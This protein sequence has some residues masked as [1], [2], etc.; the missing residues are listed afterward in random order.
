MLTA[1]AIVFTVAEPVAVGL[2]TDAAVT[3]AVLVAESAAVV[4][5]STLTH[6]FVDA[7]G[8]TVGVE[9]RAVVHVESKKLT[10][11]VPPDDD[12]V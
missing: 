2:P 8:P 5:T 9:V 1:T 4:G 10:G 3:V 7:P 6:T 11:K 12:I